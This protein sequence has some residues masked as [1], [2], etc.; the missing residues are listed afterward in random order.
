MFENISKKIKGLAKVICFIGIALGVISGISIIG[1]YCADYDKSIL[2]GLLL[3][4]IYA[5]LIG[6]ISWVGSFTLYG[7]GQHIED[8][9]AIRKIIES[10]QRKKLTENSD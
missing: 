10:E 7:Y 9:Q 5:L 1:S 2:A 6:V 3:G 8:T 4:V